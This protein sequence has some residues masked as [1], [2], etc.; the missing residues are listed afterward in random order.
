MR[1]KAVAQLLKLRAT[2]ALAEAARCDTDVRVR[3]AALEALGELQQVEHALH[4]HMHMSHVHVH[5][6]AHAH[7]HAHVHAHAHA[8]VHAHVAPCS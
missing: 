8:H 4:M 3:E 7:A 1:R 6:H 2:P 5:A